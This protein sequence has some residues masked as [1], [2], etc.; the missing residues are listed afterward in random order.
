MLYFCIRGNRQYLTRKARRVFLVPH[1]A[2]ER[3]K[4]ESLLR[5]LRKRYN[6]NT[7]AGEERTIEP[8]THIPAAEIR[9]LKTM[10]KKKG[11]ASGIR[12]YI[13]R[14]KMIIRRMARD[15]SEE[16]NLIRELMGRFYKD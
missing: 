13:R 1:P 15:K 9:F 12:K 3:G 11:L 7:A 10:E 4:R 16:E 2:P 6:L 5:G 8:K 14:Q